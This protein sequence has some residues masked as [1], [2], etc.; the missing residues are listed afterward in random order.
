MLR[1]DTSTRAW[2]EDLFHHFDRSHAETIRQ[3]IIQVKLGDFPE[4]WQLAAE[5]NRIRRAPPRNS[6]R[7][8]PIGLRRSQTWR[9]SDA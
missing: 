9:K 7:S 2:L 8:T 3:L 5:E 6:Q 1:L 4:S